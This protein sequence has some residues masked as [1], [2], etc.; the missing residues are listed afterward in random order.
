[1]FWGLISQ[2]QVFKVGLPNVGFKPFTPWEKLWGPESP[3]LWCRVGFVVSWVLSPA[4]PLLLVCC[5][6]ELPQ[7]SLGLRAQT[8]LYVAV[9][10]MY[11]WELCLGHLISKRGCGMWLH[12][13][14]PMRLHRSQ[15]GLKPA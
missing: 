8:V 5:C 4:R 3:P 2:V 10:L 14:F 1:M 12:N 9:D 13:S 15:C 7:L 11:L 6:A